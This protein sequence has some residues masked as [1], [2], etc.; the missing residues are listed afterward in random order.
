[1]EGGISFS[2]PAV[3]QFIRMELGGEFNLSNVKLTPYIFKQYV[4]I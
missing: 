3:A 2:N 1:M 4:F